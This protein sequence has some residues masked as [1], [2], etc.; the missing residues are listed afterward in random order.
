M[1]VSK[2]RFQ[3]DEKKF[4]LAVLLLIGTIALFSRNIDK[5]DIFKDPQF[6]ISGTFLFFAVYLL[7][8]VL[9]TGVIQFGLLKKIKLY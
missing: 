5:Q 7:F 9:F 8:G 6:G 1:F 2:K 3:F 4:A